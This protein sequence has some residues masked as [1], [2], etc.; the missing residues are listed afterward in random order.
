MREG[1]SPSGSI[2]TRDGTG[3]RVGLKYRILRVQIS[4]GVPCARDGTGIHVCLRSR[5]LRVRI[6]SGVLS[7]CSRT[8]IG[9]RL[10]IYGRRQ[11]PFGVRFPA[12]VLRFEI[13]KKKQ[14]GSPNVYFANSRQAGIFPGNYERKSPDFS[15]ERKVTVYH[16]VYCLRFISI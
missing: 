10:R 2:C 8:G 16:F 1:S 13:P 11:R 6:P 3:I 5:I 7:P 15:Q 4:P 14:K 12:R 9:G